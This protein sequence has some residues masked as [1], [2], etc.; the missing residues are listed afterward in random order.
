MP[1]RQAKLS[2]Y[3]AVGGGSRPAPFI[4]SNEDCGQVCLQ[5]LHFR[6]SRTQSADMVL[7]HGARC[8]AGGCG[9]VCR[10]KQVTDLRYP[11][12]KITRSPDK[13][14]SGDIS[15]TVGPSSSFAAQGCRQQTDAFVIPDCRRRAP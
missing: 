3:R 11:Q 4:A 15:L 10:S 9:G 7:D 12:T 1:S 2:E 14:Q 5:S 6:P 8:G 13:R